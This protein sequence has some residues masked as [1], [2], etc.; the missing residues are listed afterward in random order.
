MMA[1]LKVEFLKVKLAN[2]INTISDCNFALRDY[3]DCLASSLDNEACDSKKNLFIMNAEG[4]SGNTL[5]N[6]LRHIMDSM[7]G[8]T[9]DNDIPQTYRRALDVT[10]HKTTYLK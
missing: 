6:S 7:T 10:S 1:Q 9:P 8:S 4:S 3:L 2:D 5:E